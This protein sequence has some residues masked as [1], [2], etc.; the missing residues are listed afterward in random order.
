MKTFENHELGISFD[1]PSDWVS[2]Y[3]CRIRY[4]VDVLMTHGPM[5]FG[6]MRVAE[7][8]RNDV[9]SSNKTLGEILRATVQLNEIVY[10]EIQFNKYVVRDSYSATVVVRKKG[11]TTDSVMTV[12]KTLLVYTCDNNQMFLVVLEDTPE[13][14][15]FGYSP[16]ELRLVFNSF[17]FL[18]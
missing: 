1:Y 4:G 11:K 14:Y 8:I 18:C 13:N 12:E 2:V 5:S 10:K 16:S 15:E 3:N 6:I 7:K 17:R 9:I